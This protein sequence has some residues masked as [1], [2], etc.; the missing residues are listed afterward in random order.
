MRERGQNTPFF[1]WDKGADVLD[2]EFNILIDFCKMYIR[3]KSI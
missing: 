1:L 2:G 3:R